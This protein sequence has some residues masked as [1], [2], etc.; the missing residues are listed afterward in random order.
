M[1]RVIID[2]NVLVALI[3]EIDKWHSTSLK[4][5]KKL[6]AKGW[7]IIYLD[8]VVNETTSVL[9]KRLEEKKR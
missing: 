9:G 8:C 3:D 4:I 6:T 2:A 7:E 5:S 1:N